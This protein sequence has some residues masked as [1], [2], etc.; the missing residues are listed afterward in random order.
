MK[1]MTAIEKELHQTTSADFEGGCLAST[2][3]AIISIAVIC[4]C[5]TSILF[6]YYSYYIYFLHRF[7]HED[8]GPTSYLYGTTDDV[9]GRRNYVLSFLKHSRRD[10]NFPAYSWKHQTAIN[11]QLEKIKFV[12][13]M[14]TT[15][16]RV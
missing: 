1:K 13:T 4:N 7:S 3:N 12:R 5:L 14:N 2:R 16:H 11:P 10:I 15:N 6:R 8:N 9:D